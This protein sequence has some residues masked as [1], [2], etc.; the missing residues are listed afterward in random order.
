VLPSFGLVPFGDVV[1]P[2][3][4]PVP[5]FFFLAFCC[6]RF[7][8]GT[9]PSFFEVFFFPVVRHLMSAFSSTSWV[10]QALGWPGALDQVCIL[11]F[12]RL[13]RL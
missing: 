3:A 10:H 4:S 6:V 1:C 2:R 9:F 13:T 8:V 5:R 7:S 11:L 12:G